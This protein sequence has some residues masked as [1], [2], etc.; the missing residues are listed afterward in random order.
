VEPRKVE[1]RLAAILSADVVG[2]AKLMIA[3][4][5]ATYSAMQRCRREL[6]DP[7]VAKHSGR[8]FKVM[9][10]GFLVDFRSAVD[11]V[12]CAIAVQE[13][14]A[15]STVGVA[16]HAQ[17]AFRIGVNLGEVIVEGDDLIG[18]GVN[19]AAR[20]QEMA[21][22][23]S[24]FLSAIVHQQV[25]G[26]IQVE[27]ADLGERPAKKLDRPIRVFR[28]PSGPDV[29][30]Y[31]L[32]PESEKPSIVVLP[33]DNMSGDPEQE[34]FSDGLTEDI[35]TDLAKISGLLVIARNSAF[36][37]KRKAVDIRQVTRTLGVRYALEGAMRKVGTRV[38]V[39]AQLIDG[40]TG[41]H[42]WA[43]RYESSQTDIYAVQDEVTRGIVAALSVQLSPAELARAR[44]GKRPGALPIRADRGQT[45]C[46]AGARSVWPTP[47]KSRPG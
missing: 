1:R 47:C 7:L 45:A 44:A 29:Q 38:R 36:V 21:E 3:D 35:I 33:F 11:A 46:G 10:D 14:L 42:I 6:I 15:E 16:R 40:A 39:T 30:D 23:G 20:L 28:W 12:S 4:E 25:A 37:Y 34:F 43:E 32:P 31:P 26:K 24:V 5:V 2:Y 22:P 41:G 27:L 17:I 9:G 8:V 13:R 19:I 18:D